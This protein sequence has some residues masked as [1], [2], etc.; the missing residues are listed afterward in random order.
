MPPSIPNLAL[1]LDASQITGL[2]DG[3]AV[4][5]WSDASG[6]GH[7]AIQLLL[8]NRPIYRSAALNGR[9]VVRFDGS[10]DFLGLTGTIVSGSQARTVFFVARPDTVGNKGIVDL[11]NGK[12]LGAGFLVTPEYGVRVNGGSRLW[13]PSAPTQ[14]AQ[15]GVVQFAGTNTAGISLWINGTLRSA[16]STIAA[17]VQTS[18]SGSVGTWTA[19]PVGSN[20][21][22]GDI[23]EI[24]V[25][26]R[27]LNATERQAVHQYLDT[28]Y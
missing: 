11:G 3:T 19:G 21:F 17:P 4:S 25:Y 23:A 16:T 15:I 12:T 20:N 5:Q 10:N 6:Q 8:Q 24:I 2:P 14:A 1:W 7:H 18:G 22:D 9:P 26:G 13:L 27:A 28:K